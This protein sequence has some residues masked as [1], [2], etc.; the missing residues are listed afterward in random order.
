MPYTAHNTTQCD[1][2][3]MSHR[4]AV[5][6]DEREA[7]PCMILSPDQ[8]AEVVEADVDEDEREVDGQRRHDHSLRLEVARQALVDEDGPRRRDAPPRK[9]AGVLRQLLLHPDQPQQ[10]P[11]PPPRHRQRH[12]RRCVEQHTELQPVAHQLPVACPVRLRAEGV[13]GGAEGAVEDGGGEVHPEEGG[14]GAGERGG[15]QVAEE[16]E[17]SQ[18]LGGAAEDGQ[19]DGG[20]DGEEGGQLS[21]GEE[22]GVMAVRARGGGGGGRWMGVGGEGGGGERGFEGGVGRGE[23]GLGVEGVGGGEG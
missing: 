8:N 1:T 21:G 3:P 10:P 16:G 23:G 17:V 13:D 18:R 12:R 14:R 6:G 7:A 5:R 22:G 4:G 2:H 20:G 9:H 11:R 19:G 15:G